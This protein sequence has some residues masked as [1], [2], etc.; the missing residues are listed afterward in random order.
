M[1]LPVLF[2]ADL[3]GRFLVVYGICG[4]LQRSA[5]EVGISPAT[6]RNHLKSDPEF[7]AAFKEAY[8]DFQEAIEREAYRRAFVGWEENVYYKGELAG[9]VRKFDSRM[10]E[11]YLKRHLPEYKESFTVDHKISGGIMAVPQV[12]SKEEWER[13]NAV[14]AEVEVVDETPTE[15]PDND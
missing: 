4:Q 8:G 15:E 12:E 14:D 5:K 3:K 10:L 13:R 9:T 1:G 7:K 6:V 11:L 2:D